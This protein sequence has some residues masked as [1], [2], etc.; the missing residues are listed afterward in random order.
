MAQ[1]LRVWH[2][3]QVPMKAFQVETNSLQEAVKIKN[4]LADYDLFQYENNVKGDYANANGIEMWDETIS[5]QELVE[6]GL[7]DR[8][9][10]WY[11]ETEDG[12]FDDPEEYLNYLIKQV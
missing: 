9:V 11:I 3:P 2:I 8:W 5:D 6:M 12:F 1:K 4:A 10:D 7:E